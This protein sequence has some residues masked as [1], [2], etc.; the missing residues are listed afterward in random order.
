MFYHML[1]QIKKKNKKQINKTKQNKTSYHITNL[2]ME[3]DM[4]SKWDRITILF[5][6]LI[7]PFQIEKILI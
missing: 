1:K 6:F 7:Y 3:D 5:Y 2:Y 4:H